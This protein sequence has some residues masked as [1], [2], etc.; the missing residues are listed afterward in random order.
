VNRLMLTLCFLGSSL[1]LQLGCSRKDFLQVASQQ[2]DIKQGDVAPAD[3]TALNPGSE[4]QMKSTSED[5]TASDPVMIDGSFLVCFRDRNLDNRD[6]AEKGLAHLGCAL[7]RDQSARERSSLSADAIEIQKAVVLDKKETETPLSLVRSP[8][9]ARWQWVGSYLE[10]A[11]ALQLRL[12]FATSQQTSREAILPLYDR[13]P[14]SLFSL[15]GEKELGP[16]QIRIAKTSNCLT[17]DPTWAYN[18]ETKVSTSSPLK[19]VDCSQA[20]AFMATRFQEGWSLHTAN[21]NP[22]PAS[23]CVAIYGMNTSLCQ[24]SCIDRAD[25]GKTERLHLWGC[26][27]SVEAQSTKLTAQESRILFQLNG[28]WF[29]LTGDSVAIVAD[30]SLALEWSIVSLAP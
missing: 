14:I 6:P 22:P 11:P 1:L 8:N 25:Y 15:T 17:G 29:G 20:R 19:I 16:L 5:M 2:R 28:G 13:L 26:T 30:K 9:S 23:E 7:Y 18:A 4:G 12:T 21:P 24:R 27:T 10:Q 3:D